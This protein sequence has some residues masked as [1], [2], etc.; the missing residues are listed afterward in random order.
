MIKYAANNNL[1]GYAP[2]GYYKLRTTLTKKGGDMLTSC[3][4][5]LKKLGK[6]RV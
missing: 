6:K 3:W 1:A 5:R 2:L 4:G